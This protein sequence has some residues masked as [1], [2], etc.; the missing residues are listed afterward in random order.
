MLAGG[1]DAD[2]FTDMGVVDMLHNR[3]F[4]LTYKKSK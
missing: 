4:T 3:R 2:I 1:F